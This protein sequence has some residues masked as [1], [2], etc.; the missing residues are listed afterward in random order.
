MLVTSLMPRARYHQWANV[1]LTDFLLEAE[2]TGTFDRHVETRSKVQDVLCR[3]MAVDCRWLD[4]LE[5]REVDNY[6]SRFEAM[7]FAVLLKARSLLDARLM[8]A[9]KRIGTAPADETVTASNGIKIGLPAVVRFMLAR[10]QRQ[11]SH[12]AG[13]VS[14]LEMMPPLMGERLFEARTRKRGGQPSEVSNSIDSPALAAV[15]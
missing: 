15:G 6:A 8:A 3:T 1:Q 11:R 9:V 2:Q 13:I 12:V 14:A 10:N 4:R 5:G 7:D